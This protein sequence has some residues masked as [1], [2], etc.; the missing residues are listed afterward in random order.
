MAKNGGDEAKG[1]E[2]KD[3]KGKRGPGRPP[4]R[5]H[6]SEPPGDGAKKTRGGVKEVFVLS[7]SGSGR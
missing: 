7:D 2:E 3:S 5:S 4:K 6:S 1:D